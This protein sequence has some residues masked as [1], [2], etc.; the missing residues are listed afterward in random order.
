M[1]YNV[2]YISGGGTEYEDG[3]WIV[4]R[5]P[6][7]I[8]AEKVAEYM[9]GVYAMHKVGEKIRIGAGTGNPIKDEEDD[10]SFTV[11]FAQAGTPYIFTPIFTP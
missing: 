8:I 10:G 9:S 5:T 7:R 2:I 1:K 11:Y 3:V 6:K 4:K